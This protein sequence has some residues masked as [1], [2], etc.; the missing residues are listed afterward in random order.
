MRLMVNTDRERDVND[1]FEWHTPAQS[2]HSK[3]HQQRWQANKIKCGLEIGSWFLRQSFWMHAYPYTTHWNIRQ[4]SVGWVPCHSLHTPNDLVQYPREVQE[5]GWGGIP[6]DGWGC[7]I[8]FIWRPAQIWP[9]ERPLWFHE[10]IFPHPHMCSTSV[11]K[12]ELTSLQCLCA[13]FLGPRMATCGLGPSQKPGQACIADLY[14]VASVTVP[15]MVY[16]AVLVST[17]HRSPSTQEWHSD[18]CALH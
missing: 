15:M 9:R 3:A 13:I 1:P 10:R 14:G 12:Q 7:A 8:V 6:C 2:Q 4:W 17:F 11:P 5:W 18:R 16:V